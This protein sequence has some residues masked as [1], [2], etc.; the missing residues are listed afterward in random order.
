MHLNIVVGQ[1]LLSGQSCQSRPPSQY[2]GNT[3][4]YQCILGGILNTQ[5]TELDVVMQVEAIYHGMV[6]GDKPYKTGYSVKDTSQ[7]ALLACHASQLSVSAVEDDR[8]TE[9]Q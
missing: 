2:D 7:A 8:A 3:E 6:D 5:P 9:W 1:S 4:R